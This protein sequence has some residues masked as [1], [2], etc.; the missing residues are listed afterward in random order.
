[1]QNSAAASAATC[2]TARW[3]APRVWATPVACSPMT[4]LSTCGYY[5]EWYTTSLHPLQP[6]QPSDTPNQAPPFPLQ[7]HQAAP[8]S[9][10][11]LQ[12]S[13]HAAGTAAGTQHP[14]HALSAGPGHAAR[15]QQAPQHARS[16]QGSAGSR[17]LQD[18]WALGRQAHQRRSCAY[19]TRSACAVAALSTPELAPTGC[20]GCST[21]VLAPAAA[22]AA[23]RL[24]YPLRLRGAAPYKEHP[25]PEPAGPCG[26]H[27][28]SPQVGPQQQRLCRN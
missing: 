26:S 1:M 13:T 10:G 9:K 6:G 22:A 8:R 19:R 3:L 4:L 28:R 23:S 16:I 25:A 15:R 5:Q 21:P 20:C 14:G 18:F 24:R 27:A 2:G 12:C 17:L 11:M 7:Y